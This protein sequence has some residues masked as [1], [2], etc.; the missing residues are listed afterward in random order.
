PNDLPNAA[1]GRGRFV[2]VGA[3]K[4]GID[5][6]L[7]LLRNHIKPERLTWIMPRDSWFLDRANIQPGA[8]FLDRFNA[9]FA[10]RQKAVHSATSVAEL[11]ELLEANGC[12]LRL[13]PAVRPTM[14]RCAT[15]SQAELSQLRRIESIVRM[16]R[17]ERIESNEIVLT[18]GTIGA[19][20]SALY[21]D[22][23]TDGLERRPALTVFD[24]E[25]ITL[26]SL[27][28]CQQV[29][30]AS[31]IAHIEGAY[32]DD[33]TKNHLCAPV[34]HPNTDLDWLETTLAEQ[35]NEIRWFEHPELM[36]WLGSSRLNLFRDTFA[37]ILENLEVREHTLEML[38]S[39]LRSSNGKLEELRST[40]TL[41]R[42]SRSAV[43]SRCRVQ[44]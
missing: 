26:Q 18:D 23:S 24:G 35:R 19:D 29:F 5:A 27:R 22:C 8:Q 17:V 38:T 1:G 25:R 12:L 40:A 44:Q 13:D 39:V 28:G 9:S 20:D 21:I 32:N 43:A 34:P 2:I 16:G 3:G 37:P 10:A 42:A 36:D 11:F 14:Y 6:C 31:L 33:Q 7:W 30:S 41:R 4:T 15:V